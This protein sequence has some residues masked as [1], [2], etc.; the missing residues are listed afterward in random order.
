MLETDSEGSRVNVKHKGGVQWNQ[1][2]NLDCSLLE[3]P[4]PI[5][6]HGKLSEL[7]D[8]KICGDD[9]DCGLLFLQF[10]REHSQTALRLPSRS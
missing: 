5:L 10:T 1:A 8:L 2:R 3:T 6:D 4:L 7:E 9:A